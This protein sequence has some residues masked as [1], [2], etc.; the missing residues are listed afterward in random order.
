M[1]T[2]FP[3]AKKEYEADLWSSSYDARD[4][5]VRRLQPCLIPIQILMLE[6]FRAGLLMTWPELE[7]DAFQAE[8]VSEILG[9]TNRYVRDNYR[10]LG[11]R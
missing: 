4:R 8:F 6:M 11:N 5:P 2:F 7:Q 1:T 3:I 10:I 9:S